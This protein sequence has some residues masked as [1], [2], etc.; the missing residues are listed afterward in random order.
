MFDTIKIIIPLML[1][2]LLV[3]LPV[4]TASFAN[5]TVIITGSNTGL[6]LQ[7][8]QHITRL[9]AQRVILAVRSAEKGEK[10]KASIEEST[11]R[12]GVVEV[13]PLDLSSYASVVQFAE[14]AN[15][16]LPRLDCLISNAAVIVTEWS[17]AEDNET[18]ITVNVVSTFMLG[19]LLLPVTRKTAAEHNVQ[20]RMTYLVSDLHLLDSFPERKASNIFEQINSETSASGLR[21]RYI[22]TKTMDVLL[23]REFSKKTRSPAKSQPIIVNYVNP[24]FCQSDLGRNHSGIMATIDA[25]SRK[26][27]G[28]R[29]EIGSRTLVHGAAGSEGTNG[30]YLSDCKITSYAV[31]LILHFT[32]C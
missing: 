6:G 8:A 2:P 25:V 22:T 32:A 3:S 20:P 11:G 29:T 18:S 21:K 17:K 12:T 31:S 10:A 1:S 5:Q 30:C 9:G 15:R 27:L 19:L 7:A 26:L 23:A 13:W 24:G 28:R 4:P 16:E 14:R